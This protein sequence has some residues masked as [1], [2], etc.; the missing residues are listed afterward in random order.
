MLPTILF[1]ASTMLNFDRAIGRL[2][3]LPISQTT[4][5]ALI[6]STRTPR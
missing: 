6:Y 3:G 4:L 2:P 5:H 1:A